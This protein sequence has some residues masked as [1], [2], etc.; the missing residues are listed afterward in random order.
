MN[1]FQ[2]QGWKNPSKALQVGY[3]PLP[4]DGPY[5]PGEYERIVLDTDGRQRVV[6]EENVAPALP[7]TVLSGKGSTQVTDT[8]TSVIPAN[9]TR[10]S[11][12]LINC[13]PATVYLG[14]AVVQ[15]GTAAGPNIGLPIPPGAGIAYGPGEDTTQIYGVCAAGL[16]A[17]VVRRENSYV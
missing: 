4:G 5:T 14:D 15:A 12:V 16:T 11:L 13:G 6:V 8:P 7:A 17:V 3:V 1:K 2:E 9:T 10:A